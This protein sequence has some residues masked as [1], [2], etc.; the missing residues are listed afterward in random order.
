[1]ASGSPHAGWLDRIEKIASIVQSVATV[2]AVIVGAL[3]TYWLFVENREQ[4]PRAKVEHAV[5]TVGLSNK[6][7]L[8][9]LDVTVENSSKVL[10]TLQAG[11]VRIQQI[12]PLLDCDPGAG[13]QCPKGAILTGRTPT[14]PGERL[15]RW[16]LIAAWN[17]T[18]GG[19]ITELE[20]GEQE[21]I[22][23][24][25]VVP[26]TARSIQIYSYFAN[27][28]KEGIGWKTITIHDLEKPDIDR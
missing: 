8:L 27:V 11:A 21:K 2:G 20:P 10:L 7:R 4:L 3:W 25:F 26:S 9:R 19:E 16:P 6:S 5:Q 12:A 22:A 24:D 13:T 15:V 28:K 14:L 18:G 17:S 1:M 23:F